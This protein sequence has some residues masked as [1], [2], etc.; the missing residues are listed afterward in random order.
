MS[1]VHFTV[2]HQ[3]QGTGD[4]ATIALL[5]SG[6]IGR[7][8]FCSFQMGSDTGR[9]SDPHLLMLSL[10]GRF[11]RHAYGSAANDLERVLIDNPQTFYDLT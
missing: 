8:R 11:G 9:C 2:T 5:T 7:K 6:R 1:H 10:P 4:W 3:G